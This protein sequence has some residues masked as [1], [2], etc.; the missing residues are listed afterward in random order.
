MLARLGLDAG[1]SALQL[2]MWRLT[3]ASVLLVAWRLRPGGS[4]PTLRPA[5]K[6][7]LAVAGLFLALHFMTWFLS[8]RSLPVALST[9]LVSTSPLWAGLLGVIRPD[10]RPPRGFWLGLL[11]AGIGMLLVTQHGAGG[12]TPMLHR[13]GPLWMGDL[14]AILGAIFVVPYML[15]VQQAQAEYGTVTTVTWTYAAAAV[16]LWLIALATE[17]IVVSHSPTVW[18][19]ALGMAVVPQLLGHTALNRSLRHFTAGQVAAAMLL[20]PIVAAVPAFLFLGERVTLQQAL[21]AALLLAGVAI[22]LKKQETE[23]L[24]VRR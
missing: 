17:P 10:L 20:E 16:C 8:L 14:W 24:G 23:A 21:G 7:R 1:M 4:V 2:A 9:L 11:V 12:A 13:A 18:L 15:L 5:V 3:F 6:V 22:T 19:S